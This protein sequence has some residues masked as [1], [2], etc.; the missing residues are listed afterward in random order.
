MLEERRKDT[1][2]CIVNEDVDSTQAPLGLFSQ[3]I[4]ECGLA[5]VS[6]KSKDIPK[7]TKLLGGCQA[8]IR[9]SQ[10]IGTRKS[11]SR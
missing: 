2:S 6:P 4:A 10:W 8:A 9:V 5:D 7:G 3:V 11:S 1:R